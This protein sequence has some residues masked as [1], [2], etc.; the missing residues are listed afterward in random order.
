M[1]STAGPS[2]ALLD[3][4][5]TAQHLLAAGTDRENL[6][7]LVRAVAY[8]AV[9]ATLNELDASGDV[10]VSGVNAG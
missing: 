4:L 3:Q 5:P 9:F 1:R 10:S 7:R 6:V 2:Q 8:E